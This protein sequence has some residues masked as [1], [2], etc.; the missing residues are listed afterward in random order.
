MCHYL[1]FILIGE[2]EVT[3]GKLALLQYRI[4]NWGQR[5]N[6]IELYEIEIDLWG[7][8]GNITSFKSTP[9]IEKVH[10]K[11]KN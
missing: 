10:F 9:Y 2:N 6:A 4:G 5:M 7:S 11:L 8:S 1:N 3:T